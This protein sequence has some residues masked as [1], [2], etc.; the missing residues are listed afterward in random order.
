MTTP[1]AALESAAQSAI[2][3]AA[4]NAAS[5]GVK[6]SEFWVYVLA[7]AA[8]TLATILIPG[9]GAQGGDLELSVK[10]GGRLGII[11]ASRS[12]IYAADPGAEAKKLRDEMNKYRK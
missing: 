2:N 10:Y 7:A 12:I 11:N 8:S 6:T 5:T 3:A 4:Q 1:T 9:V